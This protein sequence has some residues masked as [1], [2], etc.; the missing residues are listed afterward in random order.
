LDNK[1]TVFGRVE[2]GMEVVM[3]IEQVKTDRNDKP[4]DDI[5]IISITPHFE[6]SS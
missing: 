4:L 6:D 1:H 5:K 2:K 3:D